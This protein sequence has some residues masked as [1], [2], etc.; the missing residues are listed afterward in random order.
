MV[1]GIL[2]DDNRTPPCCTLIDGQFGVNH[3]Y[4]GAPVT[5]AAPA[6]TL[7]STPR[8]H[9][10]YRATSRRAPPSMCRRVGAW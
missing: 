8:V 5:P 2:R 4:V 10:G 6:S 7:A 3:A 9:R 1:D